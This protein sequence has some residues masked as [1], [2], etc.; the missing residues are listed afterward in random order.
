MNRMSFSMNQ[1]ESSP[2]LGA[3]FL[4]KKRQRPQPEKLPSLDA[5]TFNTTARDDLA[6]LREI[7]T[8]RE[9]EGSSPMLAAEVTG[10]RQRYWCLLHAGLRIHAHA[11]T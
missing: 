2:N 8:A 10:V 7:M 5:D 4:G 11:L 6:E 1:L 9:D 3:V